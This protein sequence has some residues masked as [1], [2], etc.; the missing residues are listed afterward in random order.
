MLCIYLHE[1]FVL[2]VTYELFI[3]NY[4]AGYAFDRVRNQFSGNLNKHTNLFQS[5]H[6]SL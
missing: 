6:P 3:T 1:Y 2:N 5:K 4:Y